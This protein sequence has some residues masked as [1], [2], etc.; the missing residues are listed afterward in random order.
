ML[1]QAC[2]PDANTRLLLVFRRSLHFHL[3]LTHCILGSA[4]LLGP[5]FLDFSWFNSLQARIF[6]FS[7][8]LQLVRRPRNQINS[9]Q[10]WIFSFFLGLQLARRPT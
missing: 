1:A 2:S 3:G 6:S 4:F 9:L 8:G 7:L 5:H 10:V